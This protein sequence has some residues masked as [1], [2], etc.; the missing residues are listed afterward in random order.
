MKITAIKTIHVHVNP[1]RGNWTFVR[2]ETDAG[3][4]GLG[5]SS[6]VRAPLLVQAAVKRIEPLL[7]GS[8]PL[9]VEAF[10][11]TCSRPEH[12]G[13]PSHLTAMSGIETALWDIKGKA[14]DVPVHTLLGGAL[15]DRIRLYANVNRA[16]DLEPTAQGFVDAC[17]RAADDG[18]T[19]VKFYPFYGFVSE[20][21]IVDGRVEQRVIDEGL[22]RVRAVREAVGPDVD[23]LIQLTVY[24]MSFEQI[25]ELADAFAEFRPYWYQTTFADPADNARLVA[26]TSVPVASPARGTFAPDRSHWRESLELGSMNI[27]NPDLMGAG[28]IWQMRQVAAMAEAFGV[29]FSPHSPYGPVHVAA[30]VHLCA[31]LPNFCILE[32]SGYDAPWRSDTTIPPEKVVDGHIIVNDRP[33][34]GVELNEDVIGEH[35]LGLHPD[36]AWDPIWGGGVS[37][38]PRSR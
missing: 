23:I 8:D 30:D 15:R 27:T 2:V 4:S 16:H 38:R 11:Q 33:G 21:W 26:H 19:A 31:T 12:L 34:L 32:F 35:P 29:R 9:N 10:L 24:D 6:N 25:A 36:P 20:D 1:V 5:E 22:R 7:V 18:F 14:L 13:V 17:R 28:G 3:V 37:R